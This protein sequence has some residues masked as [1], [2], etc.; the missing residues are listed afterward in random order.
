MVA[1]F[2]E[3]GIE[4]V[5][6]DSVF[7]DGETID[8]EALL[9]LLPESTCVLI[10]QTSSYAER[11]WCQQEALLA[12]RSGIPMIVVEKRLGFQRRGGDIPAN[13][14]CLKLTEGIGGW[15]A[16]VVELTVSEI[17]RILHHQAR[18]TELLTAAGIDPA[19]V[20]ILGRSPQL[21]NMVDVIIGNR[22]ALEQGRPPKNLIV[23]PDP[24]LYGYEL[25][26]LDAFDTFQFVT[27]GTIPIACLATQAP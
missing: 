16:E 8:P 4:V 5:Y 19:G 7:K 22:D 20:E 11:L 25:E 14:P 9:K 10:Y 24:P 27:P 13:C 15:A 2:K 23:H 18:S 26:I 21:L 17:L 1:A 12:G 3:Y 6:D